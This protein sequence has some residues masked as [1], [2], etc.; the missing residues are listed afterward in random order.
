MQINLYMDE[1][2]YFCKKCQRFFMLVGGFSTLF[3]SEAGQG[4]DDLLLHFVATKI[5]QVVP[6]ALPFRCDHG[7]SNG[8]HGKD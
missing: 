7:S 1:R 4:L 2:L 5:V 3:H 6:E 8:H